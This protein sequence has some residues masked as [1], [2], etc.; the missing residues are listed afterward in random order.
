MATLAL[1]L[2]ERRPGR[3][4]Q[5]AALNSQLAARSTANSAHEPAECA[6]SGRKTTRLGH[7]R[8]KSLAVAESKFDTQSQPATFTRLRPM[9]WP[10][11]A[12]A[13]TCARRRS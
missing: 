8:A 2:A 9:E 10:G 4:S 11:G 6:P 3:S 5:F 7:S 12:Q 13:E 1:A